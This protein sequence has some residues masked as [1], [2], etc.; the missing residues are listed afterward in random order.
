[1]PKLVSGFVWFSKKPITQYHCYVD[2][3]VVWVSMSNSSSC[4]WFSNFSW[5]VPNIPLVI[6]HGCPGNSVTCVHNFGC[7][8][9]KE[10]Y[11]ISSRRQ[12]RRTCT[13]NIM[14]PE[15][16]CRLPFKLQ[17]QCMETPRPNANHGDEGNKAWYIILYTHTHTQWRHIIRI[18]HLLLD[19]FVQWR[20][21]SFPL[22]SVISY[23]RPFISIFVTLLGSQILQCSI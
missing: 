21:D 3:G 19:L 1:M 2:R 10:G 8:C 6:W 14:W 17:Y 4:V 16:C 5:D 23:A 15:L 13:W 11:I 9:V 22:Y 20:S 18:F 12:S 7:W